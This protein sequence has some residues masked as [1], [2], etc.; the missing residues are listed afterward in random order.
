MSN[1]SALI[2]APYMVIEFTRFR[3]IFETAGIATIVADV[4]E[5]LSE[6]DLLE[7]AGGIDGVLCGDDQF[8]ARVLEAAAP[9]L[10]IISKWG[11]GID[12]I[13][14]E[15]AKR[16]GIRVTNTPDA[17]TDAVADSVMGYLLAFARQ[18][19]WM[20]QD[21]K[22]GFW[23]K[24]RARALHECTLGVVG[25][26]RIGKAVI[27]RGRAFGMRLL[28]ND[29]VEI[30]G[31]FL[32]STGL[33]MLSLPVLLA[34]S[35]YVSLNCDLNPSSERL[36]DVKSLSMMKPG[37]VLINTSRG[38]VVD[39]AALVDSL[40]QKRIAGAALDVFEEEPL[41]PDSPLRKMENVLLAPHIANSSP[42]AW[43]RVH[44]NSLAHLFKGLGLEVPQEVSAGLSDGSIGT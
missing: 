32:E 41:P 43:E 29:I 36:M 8:T 1:L 28:G 15:T 33:E 24:R 18:I 21:M 14:L 16:L 38:A 11:T 31:S 40:Q 2:S 7:Y 42:R 17:F 39:Q 35:D 44:W 13:D 20:D 6:D 26:G 23:K 22:A 25:V 19:P 12:S 9:R 10:K 34:E 30:D 27:R 5:R 3:P 4:E 37:A